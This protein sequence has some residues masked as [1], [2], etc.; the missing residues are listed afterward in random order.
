M[1][2]IWN[3]LCSIFDSIPNYII[4]A[5]TVLSFIFTPLSFLGQV[6]L[7]WLDKQEKLNFN[8]LYITSIC[9]ILIILIMRIRKYHTLLHTRM[10]I[11]S[12]NLYDFL[13]R[14]QSIYFETM[15]L[16]KEGKL[17]I[18]HLT[19]KYK[20]ELTNILNAL[21]NIMECYTGREIHSCIKIINCNNPNNII[22]I[23]N[24]TVSTFCRS[25]GSD[26][27]GDYEKR[28][29][30]IY[31][32]KN[33]D[34]KEIVKNGKSYFYIQDLEK[35]D[36]YLKK[37]NLGSYENSNTNYYSFYKSTIVMPIRIEI[38]KLY[39]ISKTEKYNIIGFLCV[40][41]LSTDAFLKKQEV[42]NCNIIRAFADTIYVLLSQYAHYLK[43]F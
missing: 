33:T 24:A 13:K 14:S 36:K 27:R 31:I 19:D 25:K 38:D 1:K 21:C 41:S 10:K 2:T 6:I 37:N 5:I 7:I 11:E 17:S 20:S 30:P 9:T 15:K 8:Y 29:D 3:R 40:D 34:F 26:D 35:Y 23:D 4:N 12:S 16:H 42:F 28:S 32:K 22:D 18:D 39:D 43:K